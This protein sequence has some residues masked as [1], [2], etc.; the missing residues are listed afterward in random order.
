MSTSTDDNAIVVVKAKTERKVFRAPNIK[1]INKI[2]EAILNNPKLK[3]AIEDL[4]SNYDFEIYKSVWR[5]QQLKA[6]RVALQMPEGLLMFALKICDIIE[7]FTE[8]D[9]VIMG[10]VTYGACCVDDY[11]AKAL[12]VDLLLHYG[13]SCL[14]PIDQTQSIKMLYIFVNINIDNLHL[15][16]TIKFN[17]NKDTKLA[18]VSTVQFISSL[19]SIASLLRNDGYTVLI[20]QIKPLSPGEILGCTSPRIGK[21]EADILLYLGDGRFHLESIMIAN[22]H[23]TAY[24]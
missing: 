19:H 2:P 5:I 7:E 16:D 15:L 12:G 21:D 18:M 10:D 22:P 14:I 4:P 13:H 9:T 6:K 11:T 1:S 8:A 17:F 3:R 24:R 23:L 20:P